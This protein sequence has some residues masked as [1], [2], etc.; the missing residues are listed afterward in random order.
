MSTD[1]YLEITFPGMTS[2]RV[3]EIRNSAGEVT[4]YELRRTQTAW[5][6][7]ADRAEL[8][9]LHEKMQARADALNRAAEPL[10]FP[11]G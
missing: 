2:W 11:P 1:A 3:E 10:A 7:T 5:G 4:G 8:Q 6:Q 9:E